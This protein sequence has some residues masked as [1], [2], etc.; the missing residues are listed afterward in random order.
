MHGPRGAD[1]SL[2]TLLIGSGDIFRSEGGTISR[3]RA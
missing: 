3:C 1:A 2:A